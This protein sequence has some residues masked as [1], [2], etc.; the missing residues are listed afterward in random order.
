VLGQPG[1]QIVEQV[2]VVVRDQVALPVAHLAVPHVDA[3]G[4]E[5][6]SREM[7][8]V[9]VDGLLAVHTQVAMSAVG[10][11]ER[12]GVVDAPERHLPAVRGPAHDAAVVDGDRILLATQGIGGRARDAD[13]D[14]N[15]PMSQTQTD[16]HAHPS[17]LSIFTMPHRRESAPAGPRPSVCP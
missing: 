1:K 4:I 11:R 13:S 16:T 9:G 7:E 12:R 3:V 15:R 17:R 8:H 5:A 6:E 2:E 10:V 14:Q